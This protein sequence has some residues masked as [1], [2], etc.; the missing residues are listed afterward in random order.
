MSP[1]TSL[2]YSDVY[3]VLESAMLVAINV[4]VTFIVFRYIDRAG[5]S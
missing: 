2:E 4:A 3:S 1:S 5:G